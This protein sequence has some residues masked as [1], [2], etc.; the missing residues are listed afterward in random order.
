MNRRELLRE[1]SRVQATWVNRNTPGSGDVDITAEGEQSYLGQVSAVFERARDDLRRKRGRAVTAARAEA[2]IRAMSG[3][4]L[5]FNP[6]QRRDDEG[7]WT[8]GAPG[9]DVDLDDDGDGAGEGDPFDNVERFPSRY[10]RKYGHVV[11]EVNIGEDGLFVAK[12]D[13]DAFH[14]A[15]GE[16]DRQVLLELDD[17]KA[18]SLADFVLLF[19]ENQPAFDVTDPIS[20]ATLRSLGDGGVRVEWP[21]GP[22]SDLSEDGATFLQEALRV[23]GPGFR[24]D[25]E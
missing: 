5:A 8:D 2:A 21:D 19:S 14:V 24:D 13:K 6:G 17:A 9:I 23:L 4:L 10:L 3:L 12:T 16:N 22:A 1:M 25:E 18:E 20:G 15:R 7:K 11:D